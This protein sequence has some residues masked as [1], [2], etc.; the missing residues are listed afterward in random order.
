M[1]LYNVRHF[2]SKGKG[3]QSFLSS[4]V[5]VIPG[6][7]L[8]GSKPMAI[9]TVSNIEKAYGANL[10][11]RNVSFQIYPGEKVALVGANGS[12]KSTLARIV[13]GL[14]SPDSGSVSSARGTQVAYLEQEPQLTA[15][16]ALRDAVRMAS[17]RIVELESQL[18]ATAD[19]IAEAGGEAAL[20]RLVDKQARL[21][22]EYRARGGYAYQSR[23]E[24]VLI[25]L[26]FEPS[27]FELPVDRL[28]GGEKSRA[29][30]AKILLAE[31]D[32][33]FL[34]EP[35]NHLDIQSTEWLEQFLAKS[36]KAIVM[37]SHDR[38]FLDKVVHR[39]LDLDETE[40]TSYR[41]DYT[42]YAEC[43]QEKLAHQQRLYEEQQQY[44]ARQE[45]F[46]QRHI[47]GQRGREAKGRRKRLERLDRLEKPVL[48]RKQLTLRLVPQVRGGNDVVVLDKVRKSFGSKVLI[49]ELGLHVNRGERLGV[50]GPNGSGKTTLLE[51]MIGRQPPTSGVAKLGQNLVVGYYQQQRRDLGLDNTVLDEIREVSPD[52]TPG[53]L[54]GFL[55]CFLFSDDDV[56]K[57]VRNLSGGEQ[58]RVALAKLVLST[59]NV[60]VL[61][62]PTNDLDIPSRTVLEEALLA[63]EG[64]LM[65]V[66]HDRYFLNRLARK[67]LALED[68]RATLYHGGYSYYESKR[69]QTDAVAPASEARRRSAPRAT[70]PKGR[71]RKRKRP[72]LEQL[73]QAIMEKEEALKAMTA[74]AGDPEV[75]KWPKRA[76][77]LTAEY[78]RI[79]QELDEL[80]ERWEEA[81]E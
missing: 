36:P 16:L 67:I 40:V 52:S 53:E 12:G 80:Y 59:P 60:L 72:S 62:E 78:D 10:V 35:T 49:E 55:G 25:G 2:F 4:R 9:V 19:Q 37:I 75:Y 48:T 56:F 38:Y 20:A 58:A 77:L 5:A 23:V 46:I 1:N 24:A 8:T 54:R 3:P 64:T 47:A 33:L 66:S 26:G 15:G 41:G 17:E 50:I 7:E 43:K 30:L 34:D 70:P 42:T 79:K 61:D 27:D 57:L 31:P 51:I 63:Y 44:V 28:S 18:H 22:E 29:A 71:A 14:D 69:A 74:A 21:E 39:V 32:F 11:L 6:P 68:G 13:C 45:D 65:V 76:R 81:E 73:E